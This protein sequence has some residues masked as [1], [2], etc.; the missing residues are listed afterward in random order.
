MQRI[1]A[2]LSTSKGIVQALHSIV[3]KGGNALQIFSTSPRN[4]KPTE[5]SEATM[6]EFRETKKTLNIEPVVFHAS[7]LVNLADDALTGERSVQAL[8]HELNLQPKMD[9][10][11]SVVHV[12]SYKLDASQKK[13]IGTP[14]FETPN[15]KYK[16]VLKNIREVLE[17]TDSKSN[18]FIENDATRKVCQQLE[19][20]GNI[21]QDIGSDRIGVCLDTCHLHAAGYDLSTEKTYEQFIQDFDRIVGL[22][23]L[24]V[25]HLNDSKDP[26]GSMRDRHENLGKGNVPEPVFTHIFNDPRLTHVPKIL[27]VPGIEGN[28][29]DRENITIAKSYIH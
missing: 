28:G 13:L 16:T 4:W 23:R 21:I 27:E 19:S 11:G 6:N 26:F 8:I 17:N 1:G 24:K 10:I 9:V 25:I 12:G 7:Y 3:G 18:F 2:H 20:I 14:L 5:Y 22:D 15:E 29:P